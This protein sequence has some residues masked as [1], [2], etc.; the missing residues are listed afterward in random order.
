MPQGSLIKCTTTEIDQQDNSM[1][2]PRGH[3]WQPPGCRSH[4]A[5]PHA[6]TH[7]PMPARMALGHRHRRSCQNVQQCKNNKHPRKYRCR[8]YKAHRH[9]HKL[10]HI[11]KPSSNNNNNNTNNNNNNNNDD[12]DDD[13][14]D[15]KR[16]PPSLMPRPPQTEPTSTTKA[17]TKATTTTMLI[18]RTTWMLSE[19]SGPPRSPHMSQF[20]VAMVDA[21]ASTLQQSLQC[22]IIV[23]GSSGAVSDLDFQIEIP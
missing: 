7:V 8:N 13:H 14:D 9:Y 2:R 15:G 10:Q 12:D 3:R 18:T 20:K 17:R 6:H 5:P 23:I 21:L 4:D 19:M 16:R 22:W 11:L 1:Q